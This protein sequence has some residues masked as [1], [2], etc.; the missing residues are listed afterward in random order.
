MYSCQEIAE[1]IKDLADRKGIP[2]RSMLR[3]LNMG[4]NL[5]QNMKTSMPKADTLG[6]IADYLN[7]SVDYLLG[8]KNSN[9]SEA[10]V[11]RLKSEFDLY[12]ADLQKN[13]LKLQD[14]FTTTADDFAKQYFVQLSAKNRELAESYIKALIDTQ[15]TTR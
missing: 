14:M 11:D 15:D 13:L 4:E 12:L 9:L 2:I 5:L 1:K 8:R 3:D 7:C 10:E 6:R